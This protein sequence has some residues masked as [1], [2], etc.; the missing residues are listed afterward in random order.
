MTAVIIETWCNPSELALNLQLASSTVE[1]YKAFCQR[2]KL[3]SMWHLIYKKMPNEIKRFLIPQRGSLA[4]LILTAN[5]DMITTSS[6]G[7][8]AERTKEKKGHVSIGR[9][10]QQNGDYARLK[11]WTCVCR[12]TCATQALSI[13]MGLTGLT[14]VGIRVHI[15]T[16]NG[17]EFILRHY[18]FDTLVQ[19]LGNLYREDVLA[20]YEPWS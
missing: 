20:L 19:S 15:L 12:L 16:N 6:H 11:K 2:I 1:L 10:I 13:D 3:H 4:F 18:T 9:S 7:V 17:N 5:K 8:D 14:G